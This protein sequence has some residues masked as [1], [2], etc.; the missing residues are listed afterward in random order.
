MS[1]K[2]RGTKLGI[3]LNLGIGIAF[4]IAAAV[5]VI[6][7]NYSMRQQ[8][9]VEA[10]SKA[11]IILGRNLAVHT[12]FSQI[13][14]PSIFAWSEPF[15]SRD[16]F[17]HTWMS[18]TYALREID[19]YFKI[20]WRKKGEKIILI[21]DQRDGI[22]YLAKG[23]VRVEDEKGN[24]ISRLSDGDIFGEMAY[25]SDDGKRNATVVAETDVVLRRISTEDFENFPILHSLF[26]E[27]GKKRASTV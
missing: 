17:D 18:S 4:I 14:K 6:S 1:G 23:E 7:V 19:K 11:R 21:G 8:A 3:L 20:E 25:F 12:Y 15:R 5:V 27:I 9:L 24:I 2:I 26:A 22:Y 16:Y 13:M 10:E